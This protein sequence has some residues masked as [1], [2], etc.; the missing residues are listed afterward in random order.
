L[1]VDP[2]PTEKKLAPFC[3]ARSSLQRLWRGKKADLPV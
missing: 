2:W 3:V 1:G